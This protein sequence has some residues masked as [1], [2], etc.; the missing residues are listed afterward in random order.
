MT[1]RIKNMF[2][3][4]RHVERLRESQPPWVDT[5]GEIVRHV[6]W[7]AVDGEVNNRCYTILKIIE[8]G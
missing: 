4:L 1:L 6:V 7:M 2:R 5:I 3:V 8:E